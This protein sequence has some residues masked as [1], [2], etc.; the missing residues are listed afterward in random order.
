MKMRRKSGFSLIETLV[1][2]A[3]ISILMALYLPVLA[4][5]LRKAKEIA[6]KEGMRQ[7]HIGRMADGANAAGA[8]AGDRPGRDEARAAFRQ[9]LQ[10]DSDE[11]MIC[12][13]MLY[14]VQSDDE[15]RA[16]YHT[17][18]DPSN[19]A[20]LEWAGGGALI[21]SDGTNTY[22][23]AP[24]DAIGLQSSTIPRL[25]ESISS[26]LTDTSSGTLGG[27]VLYAD[28]HVVYVRYADQFPMTRTVA[29]LFHEFMVNQ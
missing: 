17:L 3:I 25:W 10:L 16:Y 26:V 11:M 13:E 12:S 6:G 24:M 4:K 29:T 18:L 19:T 22:Q 28:G 20:P 2:V 14:V 9:E 8:Q 5:A 27:N 15:F 7:E 1:V 23:L 21:A